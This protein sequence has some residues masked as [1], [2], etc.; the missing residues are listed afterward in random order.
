VQIV[1]VT[2][3]PSAQARLGLPVDEILGL[4]DGPRPRARGRDP[5]AE[6][7]SIDGRVGMILDPAALVR[8]ARDLIAAGGAA[9]AAEGEV[10]AH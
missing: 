1:V 9:R 10:A 8:A 5:V 6:R 2:D 7:R 4:V 3:G